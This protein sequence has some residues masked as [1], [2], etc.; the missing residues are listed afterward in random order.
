[1]FHIFVLNTEM[2]PWATYQAE[3][4]KMASQPS[5]TPGLGSWPFPWE[6]SFVPRILS[7]PFGFFICFLIVMVVL[8]EAVVIY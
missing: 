4:L 5:V 1:M 3:A 7:V 6:F 8:V 2:Q